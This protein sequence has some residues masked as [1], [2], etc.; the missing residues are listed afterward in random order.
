MN[1]YQEIKEKVQIQIM[2]QGLFL[3]KLDDMSVNVQKGVI[4]HKPDAIRFIKDPGKDLQLL[5][6]NRAN[7]TCKMEIIEDVLSSIE[8]PHREL[9]KIVVDT[10]VNPLYELLK[11]VDEDIRMNM[12]GDRN[13]QE[14]AI[15]RNPSAIKIFPQP[16]EELAILAIRSARSNVHGAEQ[17]EIEREVIKYILSKEPTPKVQMEIILQQPYLWID[18]IKNPCVEVQEY[19]LDYDFRLYSRLE[20]VNEE[21]I[22]KGI[23]KYDV[24]PYD[25]NEAPNSEWEGT[26]KDYLKEITKF[27]KNTKEHQIKIINQSEKIKDAAIDQNPLYIEYIKKPSVELQLKAVRKKPESIKL[28]EK[29]HDIVQKESVR[30]NPYNVLLIDRLSDVNAKFAMKKLGF[31]ENKIDELKALPAVAKLF[32]AELQKNEKSKAVIIEELGC[33]FGQEE[34]EKQSKNLRIKH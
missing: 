34:G 14:Q 22:A 3:G 30:Q 9:Q 8:K 12:S 25:K 5:A 28:I 31:P 29:P 19:I 32:A 11:K 4:T 18:Q 33:K 20:N 27:C 13:Y 7:D 23:R 21:V 26:E 17:E 16:E 2:K 15:H 1:K 6:F 10:G 24:F